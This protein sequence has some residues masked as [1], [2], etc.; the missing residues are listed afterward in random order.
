M[1]VVQDG[2]NSS[3]G[4][5]TAGWLGTGFDGYSYGIILGIDEGIE[6]SFSDRYS[7]GCNDFKIEVLVAGFQYDINYGIG[8]CVSGGLFTCFMDMQIQ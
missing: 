8:L 2:I 7:E 4:W 3:I 6:L 1:E 5:F